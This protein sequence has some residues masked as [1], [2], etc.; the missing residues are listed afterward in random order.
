MTLPPYRRTL[1]GAGEEVEDSTDGAHMAVNIEFV[2]MRVGPLLLLRRRHTYPQQVGVNRIYRLNDS[3]VV[4]LR[5]LRLVRRR[6]GNDLQVRVY[7]RSPLHNQIEHLLRTSHEH[8]RE[9]TLTEF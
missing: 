9:R 3:L 1:H 4:L 5:E 2:P 6:V 8:Y 7:L